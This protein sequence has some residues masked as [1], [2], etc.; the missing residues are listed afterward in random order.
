MGVLTI[1]DMY[2][3]HKRLG[4]EEG[5]VLQ[6]AVFQKSWPSRQRRAR[7]KAERISSHKGRKAVC[8]IAERLHA[9]IKLV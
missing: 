5:S 1:Y 9:D 6:P 2:I 4:D 3:P 8:M 7:M